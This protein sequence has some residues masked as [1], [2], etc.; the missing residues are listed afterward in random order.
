MTMECVL[1]T[2]L[3]RYQLCLKVR[4]MSMYFSCRHRDH[5][6]FYL[7]DLEETSN[8]GV[9]A[10]LHL[11]FSRRDTNSEFR[12]VQHTRC[13]NCRADLYKIEMLVRENGR[14]NWTIA[15]RLVLRSVQ[16]AAQ[17]ASVTISDA[18]VQHGASKVE[19]IQ[20]SM[21][22]AFVA[23]SLRLSQSPTNIL[24]FSPSPMNR[25]WRLRKEA[26]SGG[27][28]RLSLIWFPT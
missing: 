15:E 13:V 27:R 20:T 14:C 4:L 24:T 12:H 18:Y 5:D 1:T 21:T 19:K 9:I 7:S 11:S 25:P 22:T 16:K 2:S 26:S 10:N 23:L 17:S 3:P 6:F 8:Q 28:L